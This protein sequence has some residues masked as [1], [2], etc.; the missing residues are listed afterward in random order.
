MN[1]AIDAKATSRVGNRAMRG[2][3]GL[4]D[5][6]PEVGRRVV[7]SLEPLRRRTDDGI[8]IVPW[9]EFTGERW[10]GALS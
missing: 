4:R 9:R 1:V 5:D 7:V 10:A 3:R 8:E 6:H 2:L